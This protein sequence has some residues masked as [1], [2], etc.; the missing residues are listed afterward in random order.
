MKNSI[1]IS[2]SQYKF[3]HITFDIEKITVVLPP[4]SLQLETKHR[5]YQIELTQYA[6]Q[7]CFMKYDSKR[8]KFKHQLSEKGSTCSSKYE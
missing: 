7:M 3:A 5:I 8:F 6:N 2:K 4:S 1:S